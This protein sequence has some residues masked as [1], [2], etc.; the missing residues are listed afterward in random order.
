[1]RSYCPVSHDTYRAGQG[2]QFLRPA[3]ELTAGFS[4][5]SFGASASFEMFFGL[6]MGRHVAILTHEHDRL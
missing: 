3:R 6:F 5:V 2:H 4:V 1:M